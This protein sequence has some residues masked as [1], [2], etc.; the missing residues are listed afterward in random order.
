MTKPD[1]IIFDLDGTLV[2]SAPDLHAAVNVAL[3]ALGRSSLDLAT[4]TY[5]VGHGVERLVERALTAT[6]GFDVDLYEK[7]LGLFLESYER[8]MTTL[9]RPYPGVVKRLSSLKAEGIPLG[10]CTNKPTEPAQKICDDLG[11]TQFFTVIAGSEPNVPKKP[12]AV[13][14]HYCIARL[15]ARAER[16][17]YVGD[18]RVDFETARNAGVPFQLFSEGYL[19][20]ETLDLEA[21]ARFSDWRAISFLVR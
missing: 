4:A 13:P 16:S 1:A 15:G 21:A 14:L 3:V 10:I 5:F 20:G 8:N 17:L 2:H 7:A 12:S 18:S 6:G 11:L 9:T 19:N